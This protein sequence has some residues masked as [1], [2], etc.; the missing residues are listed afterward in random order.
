M[1]ILVTGV[2]GRVG[3]NVA[4]Y[5][6]T[7]GHEVRGLV[8]PA[9]RAAEKIARLDIEIVEGDLASAAEVERAVAGCD[10]VFHLG[11]AFQ[12]GG[13]FTPAQY[14]DTNVKGVFNILE[15]CLARGDGL[16]H[17]IF[18]STDATMEKY[19]ADGVAEPITERSLPLSATGWYGYSKVLGE[20]LVDRYVR[21]HGLRATVFRFSQVWGAGEVLT[22]PQFRLRHF[23]DLFDG[24]TDEAGH[25]TLQALREEDDGRERLLVACDTSGRPWKKHMIEVRDIVHAFDSALEKEATYGGTYQLA[26]PEPFTWDDAVPYLAGKL[27]LPYSRVNLAGMSPTYYEYNLTAARR[28]FGYSPKVDVRE[29]IDEAIRFKNRVSEAIVPT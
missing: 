28:D 29:S 24:R 15:A 17:L 23:I 4:R 19:P 12:A 9:D 14:F 10:A 27:D 3:A 1:R 22:W 13:P 6:S 8:W 18:S 11:A 20:H 5:F 7:A 25:R 26:A 2:T 21:A 16:R